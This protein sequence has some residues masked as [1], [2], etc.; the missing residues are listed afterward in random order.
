MGLLHIKFDF[1]KEYDLENIS[2]KTYLGF[3]HDNEYNDLKDD[4]K[5]FLYANVSSE[6]TSTYY[7]ESS[8][9]LKEYD[10]YADSEKYQ[11]TIV[12][13]RYGYYIEYNSYEY[14]DIPAN[15]FIGDSG[16]ISIAIDYVSFENDV[17]EGCEENTGVD[18]TYQINDNSKISFVRR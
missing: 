1:E 5:I 6:P 11:F 18:L 9:V 8:I 14:I 13:K 15:I 12:E 4:L 16:Y 7:S 2:I 10:R 17:W 3:W